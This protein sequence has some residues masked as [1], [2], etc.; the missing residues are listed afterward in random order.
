MTANA[1]TDPSHYDVV[2]I[3]GGVSGC[4]TAYRLSEFDLSVCLI[5]KESDLACGATGANSAI[6]HSGYDPEPDSAKA[7]FNVEGNRLFEDLCRDLGVPFVRNGSLTIAF[8]DEENV[9][10]QALLERGRLN[11]VPGLEILSGEEARRLEPSLSDKVRSALHA[12]TGG[13]VCPYELTFA[14]AEIAYT[15]GTKFFF[16]KEVAAIE[17]RISPE[18]GFEITCLD[19]KDADNI[20][21][22]YGRIVVNAAGAYADRI[23]SLA[24]DD[25][26]EI[27]PRRGE[28]SIV[29][30]QIG[31]LIKHTIFQAPTDKGKGVLV[32]PAVDE[33]IIVGPNAHRVTDPG[34]TE[35]TGEGIDEIWAMAGKS[36]PS[37]KRAFSIRDFAGIRATPSTHDFILGEAP[38]VRD[39]FRAAGI[40]SPGLTA[41]PAFTEVLVSEM[42]A[43]LMPE[44]PVI[45]KDAVM[46]RKAP[47]RFRDLDLKE[48]EKLLT[49]DPLYANVICR[50]ENITEAEIVDAV[51]RTIGEVTVNGVKMRTRAGMGRCQ[52]GFCLPKVIALI[53]RETGQPAECVTLAGAGSDILTGRTR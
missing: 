30:K 35:T 31:R 16:E 27:I 20:F 22:L 49:E 37:L 24:G 48:Q 39:F 2:I 50:C 6:V 40:E 41:A 51:H 52:G 3:G 25:T 32:T 47:V 33:N 18:E 42:I 7:R 29:D 4:L 34:D 36:V 9:K 8:S 12:P 53:A 1:A 46:T 23:S 21:V 44:G 13:I 26:F 15:N 14:A 38:G 10:L 11:G 17:R 45:K 5:E 28:Y 43:R 19:R